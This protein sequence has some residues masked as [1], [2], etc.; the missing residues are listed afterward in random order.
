VGELGLFLLA[1]HALQGGLGVVEGPAQRRGGGGVDEIVE[2]A[3]ML[4]LRQVAH[5][6]APQADQEPGE[7][8]GHQPQAPPKPLLRKTQRLAHR[9]LPP[10]LSMSGSMRSLSTS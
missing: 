6:G 10:W 4:D 5:Q 8:Q 2:L 3:L 9:S 7:D 1:R